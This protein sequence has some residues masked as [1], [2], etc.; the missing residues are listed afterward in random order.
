VILALAILL[1][2]TAAAWALLFIFAFIRIF[3]KK[4]TLYLGTARG[5]G[6]IGFILLVLI[7][8]IGIMILNRVL[9]ADGLMSGLSLGVSS[10][11]LLISFIGAVVLAVLKWSA[12]GKIKKQVKY[13][14]ITNESNEF[15]NE[16]PGD[17]PAENSNEFSDENNDR[18]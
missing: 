4:K 7:P 5:I 1:L 10:V 16:N 9:G 12:Y 11:S 3:T 6:I 17:S 13:A 14:V 8:W 15:S 2:A 18:W